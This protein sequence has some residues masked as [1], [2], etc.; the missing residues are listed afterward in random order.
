[1]KRRI[2]S[3]IGFALILEVWVPACALRS[4][5]VSD[6]E[7]AERYAI[8]RGKLSEL[9][10]PVDIAKTQI[11]ISKILLDFVSSA[12]EEGEFDGLNRRLIQ[13]T[14]SIQAARDAMVGWAPDPGQKPAGYREL[15]IAT[16]E[17]LRKLERIR[18]SLDPAKRESVDNARQTTDLIHTEM[19]RLLSSSP[20]VK[21]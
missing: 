13:Y 2:T 5:K 15:E 9:T 1:M 14:T 21:D 18:S 8:E 6:N 12:L 4:G 17:H 20:A 7:R 10:D 11:T 3:L 16:R 19:L